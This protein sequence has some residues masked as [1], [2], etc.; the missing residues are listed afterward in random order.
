MDNEEAALKMSLNDLV[1]KLSEEDPKMVVHRIQLL[2]DQVDD[3]REELDGVIKDYW[4]HHE[5]LKSAAVMILRQ[6]S[7]IK[8]LI[9]GNPIQALA[10]LRGELKE[11]NGQASDPL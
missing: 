4:V 9:W 3:L 2:E 10:A 6:E 11:S 1:N 7:A 8:Q 5:I